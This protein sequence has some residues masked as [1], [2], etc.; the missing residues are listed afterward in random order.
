M[1]AIVNRLLNRVRKL[2]KN[3]TA[4]KD[5]EFHD[6]LFA[7]QHHNPFAFSYSGYV[8]IR[9]FADLAAPYVEPAKSVLDLGCGPAEITCELARR[10]P[11]VFFLGVDHSRAGIERAENNARMLSL[12][13]IEFAVAA[14]EEFTA[15]RK[16]DIVL[17]FDSFHHLAD[18]RRLLERLKGSASQFLLIEPR[19][20]WKGSHV[21]DLDFD[22]IMNDL[23]NMRR[24]IMAK[25][26]EAA[27]SAPDR[28]PAER[29]EK[30]AAQARALENRYNLEEFRE[31]FKGFGLKIRGTISGLEA[32]PPDPCLESPS[33]E[34]FG[35]KAY[36]IFRELDEQIVSEHIDILAKHWVI[37]A[38]RDLPGDD[39]KIPKPHFA[40]DAIEASRGPYDVQ[41]L[42][43]DGPRRVCSDS[44]FRVQ[45]RFLN[46]SYRSL[47]SQA[48]ENPDFVSYRWLDAHGAT[49]VRDGLRTALTKAVGPGEQCGSELRILSPARP[50]KYILAIDLVQEGK[51]WYSDA[52]NPSL[53]IRIRV[54]KK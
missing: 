35:K 13:N 12:K 39:I 17:M 54:N 48:S 27:T 8:T 18:P 7:E 46:R 42:D 10:F 14:I 47:S 1:I 30:A 6:Q 44:E 41:F 38:G 51:T 3:W 52:G 9:R 40:T 31:L 22:W 23:E 33:R 15:D 29:K 24:R 19:G 50:G 49:A 53:R 34:F 5:R 21:R 4:Q 16:F 43:Y 26:P 32:F 45:V 11:D 2:K 28:G 25:I 36:E 37:F 20:D